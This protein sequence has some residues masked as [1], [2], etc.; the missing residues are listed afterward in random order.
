M[1]KYAVNW[2][3]LGRNLEIDDTLLNIIEKD[4]PHDCER[5]CS[6][7]LSEWLD[8]TPHASWKMLYNAMDKTTDNI[9]DVEK[10]NG[11]VD[12][13][14]DAGRKLKTGVISDAINKLEKLGTPADALSDT[15]NKLGTAADTLLNTIDKLGNAADTLSDTVDKLGNAADTL[16]DTV[17]KLDS[18]V[19]ILPKTVEQLCEAVNKLSEPVD[20][21][22][23]A[24]DVKWD[25]FTGTVAF[26]IAQLCFVGETLSYL[27]PFYMHGT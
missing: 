12:N 21:L 20:K 6:E 14:S 22:H 8:Q 13:L 23:I 10:L 4:F 1:I 7:M 2:K 27:C 24:E 18:A 17:E 5:C 9:P 16:P 11:A 3:Q 15:V 25:D 19:N 26:V